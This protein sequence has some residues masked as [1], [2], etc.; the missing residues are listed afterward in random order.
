MAVIIDPAPGHGS[1]LK[2]LKETIDAER[3]QHKLI[4]EEIAVGQGTSKSGRN[5]PLSLT[6]DIFLISSHSCREEEGQESQGYSV[7][8]AAS[9]GRS[10]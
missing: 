10:T 5:S 3:A 6:T 7:I 8:D 2:R 4:M 9:G 1:I